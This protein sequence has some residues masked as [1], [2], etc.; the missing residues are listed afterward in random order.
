M[1]ENRVIIEV[2]ITRKGKY[3]A[4]VSNLD[5]LS[6]EEITVGGKQWKAGKLPEHKEVILSK[7]S[8][9]HA[10]LGVTLDQITGA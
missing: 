3:R 5:T 6:A 7:C 1:P 8:A 10:R 4:K 2:Y 9:L